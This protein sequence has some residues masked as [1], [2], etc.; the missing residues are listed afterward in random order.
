MHDKKDA[1]QP[2]FSCS[3]LDA[4]K[5]AVNRQFNNICSA[6]FEGLFFTSNEVTYKNFHTPHTKL[7]ISS[8]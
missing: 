8:I 3:V 2:V 7:H 6:H 1:Q 4:M 5:T